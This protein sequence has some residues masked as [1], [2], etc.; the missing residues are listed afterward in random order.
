QNLR[1]F[2]EQ[3]GRLYATDLAYDAVESVAPQAVD[4]MGGTQ[5]DGSAPETLD[6]A[7]L[8]F[9][10]ETARATVQD[11]GLRAWLAESGALEADGT[12]TVTGFLPGWA[13][14]DRVAAALTKVWVVGEIL[15]GFGPSGAGQR[16]LTV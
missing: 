10:G 1:A 16:A 6:A 13:M 4:F 11:E 3:G 15:A 5:G 2:L 9:G 8:G 14:I 12:M 7:Q